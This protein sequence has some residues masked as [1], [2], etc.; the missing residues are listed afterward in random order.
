MK[1]NK[2]AKKAFECEIM[3]EVYDFL[4]NRSH[5]YMKW[6]EEKLDYV[7]HDKNDSNYNWERERCE[8]IRKIME[9]VEKMV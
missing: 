5:H 9:K 6:D 1:M 2:F 8:I 3:G 7:E 4:E